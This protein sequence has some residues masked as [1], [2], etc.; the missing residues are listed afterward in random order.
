MKRHIPNWP[1][2]VRNSRELSGYKFYF[3]VE[4]T[5]CFDFIITE[6]STLILWDQPS[7]EH[8]CPVYSDFAKENIASL[9]ITIKK[10]LEFLKESYTQRHR[11]EKL[12]IFF[13]ALEMWCKDSSSRVI[14]N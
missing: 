8:L 11:V 3:Y 7:L 12:A 1:K 14:I 5:V 6:F 10:Y 13:R 2:A 9:M 4:P